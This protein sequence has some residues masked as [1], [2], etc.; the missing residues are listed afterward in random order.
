M[1]FI[2]YLSILTISQCIIY[3]SSGQTFGNTDG[4]ISTSQTPGTP[5]SGDGPIQFHNDSH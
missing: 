2:H 3:H 1:S 5:T 4:S